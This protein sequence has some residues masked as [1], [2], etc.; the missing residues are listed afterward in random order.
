MRSGT[1]RFLLALC[2]AVA[3]ISCGCRSATAPPPREGGGVLAF[4]GTLDER[5]MKAARAHAAYATG[6]HHWASG[7]DAEAE[8][9]FLAALAEDPG[10]A[11]YAVQAAQAMARQKKVR[12][13]LEFGEKF[14]GEHGG[15]PML[16][17]L[18]SAYAGA[19]E[20][21]TAAKRASAAVEA[22]PEDSE[23]WRLRAAIE[24]RGGEEP[25]R[26]L[27]VLEEGLGKA[28]PPTPLREQMMRIYS[29]MCGNLEDDAPESRELHWKMIR[30]LR[31]IDEESPGDPD[32]LRLLSALLLFEGESEEG[33]RAVA[34]LERTQSG[35]DGEE[36][37]RTAVQMVPKDRLESTIAALRELR[38]AG[39]APNRSWLL[40]AA[41]AERAGLEED[42][43]AAIR[44]ALEE[45]PHDI[46]LWRRYATAFSEDPERMLGVLGDALKA[47]PDHPNLLEL[48]GVAKLLLHRYSAGAKDL[49][50]A[51][52]M[53]EGRSDVEPNENFNLALAL[54]LT[55]TGRHAEAAEWL[56]KAWEADGAGALEAFVSDASFVAGNGPRAM[57]K[58][59]Q[60]FI[61]RTG[62]AEARAMGHTYLAMSHLDHK[63][64]KAAAR[65]F[66]KNDEYY[67]DARS[68]PARLAYMHAVA[69]DLA[70]RKAEAVARLEA[71]VE[72]HPRFAEARNYLAYTWAVEG[73][74]LEEAR[75]HVGAALAEDPVNAAYLDTLA[76][77]LYRMGAYEEAWE[78]IELADRLRPGDDEITEHKEAI[79]AAME[80]D[81]AGEGTDGDEDGGAGETMPESG[82]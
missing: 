79:R 6:I 13:S 71:L 53:F 65:E 56:E 25:E 47:N 2:A 75:R 62:D 51:A 80:G 22:A 67:P 50:R 5:G 32:N 82:E 35:E 42:A 17:W 18:A 8:R 29:A 55:R 70:G 49:L 20:W 74:R 64:Y 24:G 43:A 76:W 54:A 26:S 10:N 14:A 77:V 81:A 61:R 48:R 34:R 16:R 69:L 9:C 33:L 3:G 31:A 66:E 4:G 41:L 57:A 27:E 30:Q 72:V 52:E 38:E 12:E 7:E 15:A 45:E 78:N 36:L 63:Q 40:E 19:K 59:M 73:V 60:E 46:D 28:K 58:T 21:E 68:V 37:W 23:G 44:R 39:E 1:K 11:T